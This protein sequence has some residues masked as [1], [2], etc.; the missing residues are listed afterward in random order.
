M[1]EIGLAV[2]T[3]KDQEAEAEENKKVNEII[4]KS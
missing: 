4:P 3:H 2:K 1:A